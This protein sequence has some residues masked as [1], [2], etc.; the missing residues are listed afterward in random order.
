MRAQRDQ[1]PGFDPHRRFCRMLPARPPAVRM[2]TL[3]LRSDSRSEV[4]VDEAFPDPD[5]C[6]A[7]RRHPDLLRQHDGFRRLG[8]RLGER[9]DAPSQYPAVADTGNDRILVYDAPFTTDMSASL[10]LGESGYGTEVSANTLEWPPGQA[11]DP[12]GDLWVADS[13]DCRGLKYQPPFTTDM[14]ASLVLGEPNFTVPGDDLCAAN[15]PYS[16]TTGSNGMDQPVSV[17]MDAHG[18]V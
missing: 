11:M 17:A 18:D 12:A 16:A 13:N 15:P 8:R 1:R 3:N 5:A 14:S 2:L 10:V 9:D 6:D 4:L 7:C